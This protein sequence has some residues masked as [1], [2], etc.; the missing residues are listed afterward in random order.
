M[1]PH[2][3]GRVGVENLNETTKYC[4]ISVCGTDTSA[5]GDQCTGTLTPKLRLTSSW[6][7]DFDE[8]LLVSY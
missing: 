1:N 4:R 7:L 2:S 6:S 5:P 8:T 3:H